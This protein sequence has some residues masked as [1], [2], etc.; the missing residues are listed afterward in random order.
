M[1]VTSICSCT[2]NVFYSVSHKIH[3]LSLVFIVV[4]KWNYESR[5]Q[6]PFGNQ[7][8][9]KLCGNLQFQSLFKKKCDKKRQKL[10]FFKF[11]TFAILT[12][13]NFVCIVLD[14]SRNPLIMMY[15]THLT[16]VIE[17][18]PIYKWL[19]SSTQR[20]ETATGL[21]TLYSLVVS[22]YT[23]TFCFVN[24]SVV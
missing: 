21:V 22:S 14:S 13:L 5:F 19:T 6:C 9:K 17:L 15:S 24:P 3:R 20:L 1:S 12:G 4:C 18:F 11:S 10:V 23:T 16:C 2:H 8:F 7:S